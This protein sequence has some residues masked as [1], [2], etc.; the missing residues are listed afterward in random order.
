VDNFVV[1][2]PDGLA[3]AAVDLRSSKP[4]KEGTSEMVEEEDDHVY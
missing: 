2:Q 1:K 3:E 4:D